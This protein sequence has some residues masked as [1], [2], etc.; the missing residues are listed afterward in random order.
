MI[1]TLR[2]GE[3][4]RVVG[5]LGGETGKRLVEATNGARIEDPFIRALE[6]RSGRY[7]VV[8][9]ACEFAPVP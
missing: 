6:K 3:L 2:R 1:E 9:R 7:V 4:L 8:E 5:E